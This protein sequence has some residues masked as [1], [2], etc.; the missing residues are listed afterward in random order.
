MPLTSANSVYK[1]FPN[2]FAENVTQHFKRRAQT[3]RNARNNDMV[4]QNLGE[5]QSLVEIL[6][7]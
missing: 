3:Y 2:V 6:E 7:V 5:L 1:N 4:L